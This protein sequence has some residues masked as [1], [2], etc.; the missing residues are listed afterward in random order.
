MD[1]S[2]MYKNDQERKIKFLPEK[3]KKP[4]PEGLNYQTKKVTKV[5]AP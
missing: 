1:L 5:I 3:N 2:M 4:K